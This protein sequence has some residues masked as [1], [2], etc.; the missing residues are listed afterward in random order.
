MKKTLV[1][2]ALAGL[3]LFAS[4]G[5]DAQS[6]N[7]TK[8]DSIITE[9]Y[10]LKKTINIGDSILETKNYKIE[11]IK[12]YKDGNLVLGTEDKSIIRKTK[13]RGGSK[14]KGITKRV[15]TDEIQVYYLLQEYH[16]DSLK[17]LTKTEK[18]LTIN[19]PAGKK[20]VKSKIIYTYEGDNIEILYDNDNNGKLSKGDKIKFY[21]SKLD[22]WVSKEIK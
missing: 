13:V 18:S 4:K 2:L 20:E 1:T 16:H 14:P 8:Y 22:Q 15:I 19:S 17:R 6:Y 3:G 12:H 5:V 21:I 10:P 7:L 9:S 11:K